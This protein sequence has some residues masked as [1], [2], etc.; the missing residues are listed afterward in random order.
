MKWTGF[1][2]N[3]CTWEPLANVR[4]LQ[5]LKEYRSILLKRFFS[6]VQFLIAACA[7]V[8]GKRLLTRFIFRIDYLMLPV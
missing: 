4:H 8:V 6:Y 3:Q 1:E 2:L 7:F 5:V